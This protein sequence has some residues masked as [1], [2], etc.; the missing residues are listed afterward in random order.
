MVLLLTFSTGNSRL[1]SPGK[2]PI[3]SQN[4]PESL[5]VNGETSLP[6]MVLTFVPICSPADLFPFL[7]FL[8]V[9]ANV[10]IS[11]TRLFENYG[12]NAP[13]PVC[14]F[15]SSNHT[16]LFLSDV[17]FRETSHSLN[18]A[19]SEVLGSG[20]GPMGEGISVS[21]RA[22]IPSTYIICNPRSGD[23]E[24]AAFQNKLD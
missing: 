23:I 10:I 14:C 12:L 17:A 18:E 1:P 5:R 20:P 11:H 19:Y 7:S 24:T 9:G 4:I 13:C 15:S 22:Q 16:L 6:S 3:L 21:A 8:Y 2:K